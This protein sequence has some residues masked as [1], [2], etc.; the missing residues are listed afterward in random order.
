MQTGNKTLYP[1]TARNFSNRR[2]R[3]LSAS[4]GASSQLWLRRQQKDPYVQEAKVMNYRARS[5]FKLI[6]MDDKLKILKPGM[7]VIDVG[8]APGSWTQVL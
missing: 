6:Q 3:K 4:L 8:A 2:P 1:L 5:A 7:T